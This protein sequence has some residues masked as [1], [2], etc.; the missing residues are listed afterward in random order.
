ME[1]GT[2]SLNEDCWTEYDRYFAH[3]TR[4]ELEKAEERSQKFKKAKQPTVPMA[5]FA[6]L[7]PLTLPLFSRTMYRIIFAILYY[8]I[9][10]PKSTSET[11]VIETL[12]LLQLSLTLFNHSDIGMVKDTESIELNNKK[13]KVTPFNGNINDIEFPTSF[14]VT[15]NSRTEIAVYATEEALQSQSIISQLRRLSKM[16]QFTAQVDRINHILS[17]FS[18][19][20]ISCKQYIEQLSGKDKQD[21]KEQ[22]KEEEDE[23]D[24]QEVK[25]RRKER[26][27]QIMMKFNQ[28]MAKFTLKLEEEEKEKPSEVQSNANPI[29]FAEV[30]NC[31]LC[32]ED[33]NLTSK[34]LGFVSF[35]QPTKLLQAAK[36]YLVK[37]PVVLHLPEEEEKEAS[38]RQQEEN[39]G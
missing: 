14:D 35:I 28:D 11:L 37:R 18:E 9:Q 15:K 10:D 3:Y 39:E 32:H 13:R 34:P 8:T 17:L 7:Q 22:S 4:A 27:A 36:E 29:P 23:K 5:P 12:S 1:Q 38:Q 31:A 16:E 2:Y 26:Q 19:K 25:R 21:T 30:S 6:S 20:D 24:E 33:T